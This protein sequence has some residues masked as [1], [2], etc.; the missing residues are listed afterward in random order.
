[1]HVYVYLPE[2]REGYAHYYWGSMGSHSSVAVA[3][4][5]FAVAFAGTAFASVIASALPRG[6][7]EEA[8]LACCTASAASVVAVV[9]TEHEGP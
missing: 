2:V 1:M 3:V 7:S 4:Q 8:F 9:G 5:A 6:C